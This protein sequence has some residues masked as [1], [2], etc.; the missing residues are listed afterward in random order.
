MLK[1]MQKGKDAIDAILEY[2]KTTTH[3]AINEKGEQLKTFDR[4]EKGWIVPIALG[5]QGIS[6]LSKANNSRDNQTQ[7]KF[8][9]SI[10]SL[11]EFIMPYRFDD[12][13]QLFWRYKTDIENNL[14][15][16]ENNFINNQQESKL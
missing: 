2:L 4:K 12:L 14:Y 13:E 10:V 3:I 8:A 6:D 9:E 1:E 15:L 11:G 5:F 7:H 16:C